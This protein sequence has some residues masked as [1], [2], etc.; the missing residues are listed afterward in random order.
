MRDWNTNLK[1]KQ[2][3]GAIATKIIPYEGLK[4]MISMIASAKCS[5][6]TKIIPYEG[7]KQKNFRP[8]F[9]TKIIA[10]KIIPYEG[11]KQ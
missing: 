10:T 2:Y 6:A 3:T 1:I 4:L 8:K 9:S 7:L 5:I 11:L